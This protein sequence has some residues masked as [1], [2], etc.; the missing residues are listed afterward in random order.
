MV[1]MGNELRP[2]GP[3]ARMPSLLSLSLSYL[4]LS[5]VRD[6]SHLLVLSQRSVP[7]CPQGKADT[8]Y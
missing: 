2:S 8:R 6:A 3:A 5:L 1:T 7:R 4:Y